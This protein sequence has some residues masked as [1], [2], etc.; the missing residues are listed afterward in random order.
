M[1]P[2]SKGTATSSSTFGR[3]TET[4]RAR[5]RRD[6]ALLRGHA[7]RAALRPK[8]SHIT[9]RICGICSVGH[10]TASLL[11][12]RKRAGGTCPVEQTQSLRKLNFHRRDARQP[13]PAR[14][15]ARRARL[16]RRGQRHPA[17]RQPPGGG[18]ARAAH[19]EARGRPVRRRSAGGTRTRSP[20]PSAGSHICRSR[21]ELEAL[22]ARLVGGRADV[23]AT[24]ELFQSLQL[25]AFERETEYVALRKPDEYCFIGG[26][27]T[28]T[29][30]VR[31]P[32]RAIARSPTSTLVRT[33]PPSTA[34]HQRAVHGRRAGAVQR[35]PRP[36]PSARA[37][38][39]A[40]RWV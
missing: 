16:P 22:R 23:D 2:A 13:R 1:S 11:R 27:I 38:G 18:A 5:D 20:W 14:V 35:Q 31:W 29:D 9:S 30:G 28:T 39:R 34:H 32:L 3:A 10:A 36:T 21:A 7:A 33:P 19:E 8:R 6:A 17:G 37:G 26:T 12:H 15:H 4:L 25:P 40:M 24:V